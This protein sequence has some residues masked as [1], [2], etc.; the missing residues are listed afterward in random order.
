MTDALLMLLPLAAFF[1]P[2]CIVTAILESTIWR[3]DQ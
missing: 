2:L 3:H 1:G